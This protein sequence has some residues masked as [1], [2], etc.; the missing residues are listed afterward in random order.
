MTTPY[1]IPRPWYA[2]QGEYDETI[3]STR[4]RLARNLASFPFPERFRGD[5][6]KR[7][8]SLIFDAFTHSGD[9]SHYHALDHHALDEGSRR[10]LEERGI[11]RSADDFEQNQ[12]KAQCGIVMSADGRISCEVNCRDHLHL[13]SFAAGF[14]ARRAYNACAAVDAALQEALPFAASYDFGYLT[15]SFED[16]GSGLKLSARIHIPSAARSGKI[17]YIRERLSVNALGMHYLFPPQF[18]DSPSAHFY[19]IDTNS[20]MEGSEIE[21]IAAFE[22]VCKYIAEQERIFSAELADNKSV[23][24][25]NCVIRAYS[26]AKTSLLLPL[27]EALDIIADLK[28]G[29][30]L[31]FLTGITDSTLG[32]LL[33]RIQPG[34]LAFVMSAG[35]FVFE[36]DIASNARLKLDRLR[37]LIIQEALTNVTLRNI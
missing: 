20:A 4:V 8:R 24:T 32:G 17:P 12:E 31:G 6:A 3:V 10:I 23:V 26:A 14:A 19:T 21:R 34:H 22:A 11:I 35:N 13:A 28:F 9:Q 5:D 1:E 7:V 30:K 16:C 2:E 33:F 15:S 25:R 18:V 37:A 27:S 29:R 36:K